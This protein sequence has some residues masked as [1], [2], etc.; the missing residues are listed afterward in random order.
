MVW[1]LNYQYQRMGSIFP[2]TMG[3]I[4]ELLG[5]DCKMKIHQ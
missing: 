5:R 2:I 3:I 1:L 4:I